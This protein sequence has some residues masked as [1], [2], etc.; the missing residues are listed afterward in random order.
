MK[1]LKLVVTVKRINNG[2]WAVGVGMGVES[3]R[4]VIGAVSPDFESALR[5]AFAT[6]KAMGKDAGFEEAV[7][8]LDD[9]V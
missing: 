3:D 8:F 5:G 7:E 6:F 9:E 4:S 2:D 1:T